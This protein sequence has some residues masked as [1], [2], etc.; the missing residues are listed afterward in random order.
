MSGKSRIIAAVRDYN[1]FSEALSSDAHIIFFLYADITEL[2]YAAQKSHEIGKRIFI[3]IDLTTGLGKDKSGIRFAK[4]AGIDG[5]ISTKASLIKAAR[6]CGLLAI[7][8]FFI[9]DSKSVS[10][11]VETLKSAKPDMIE[12]MPGIAPKIIQKLK[13]LTDTPIIAGGLIDNAD[14]AVSAIKSGAFAISTG[15]KEL[16]NYTFNK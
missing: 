4:N 3:H 16:W 6:E 5:I 15:Q 1:E 7:Q 14:E 9:V 2:E 11:T 12:I 10:T 8:R 13:K